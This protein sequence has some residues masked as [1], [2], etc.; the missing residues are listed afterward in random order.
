MAASSLTP[1]YIQY[2]NLLCK[3][4]LVSTSDRLYKVHPMC[5]SV[6]SHPLSLPPEDIFWWY[7]NRQEVNYLY[8]NSISLPQ[9]KI[10][11]S[12][13][14]LVPNFQLQK[15][16]GSTFCLY[17][18]Y[19]HQIKQKVSFDSFFNVLTYLW[20]TLIWS[21]IKEK[22]YAECFKTCQMYYFQILEKSYFHMACFTCINDKCIL[23]VSKCFDKD[24]LAACW[25]ICQFF[26][27][28]TQKCDHVRIGTS[29]F[30]GQFSQGPKLNIILLYLD[31]VAAAW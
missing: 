2:S 28:C 9:K 31:M 23:S 14:C 20:I 8:F 4:I 26:T 22:M 16:I 13:S 19:F 29:L 17:F 1:I 11:L 24:N 6:T 10:C 25:E 30:C 7:A 18:I 12:L 27:I 21:K 5:T 3:A 15:I